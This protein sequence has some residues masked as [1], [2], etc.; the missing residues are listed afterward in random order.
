MDWSVIL[1]GF[2][3]NDMSDRPVLSIPVSRAEKRIYALYWLAVA[4]SLA[5]AVLAMIYLPARPIIHSASGGPDIVRDKYALMAF[6]I[7]ILY[8]ASIAVF[9]PKYPL[10]RSAYFV[11]ITPQNAEVQ[12]TLGR[13]V[14][15][16]FFL[17]ITWLM[18][19]AQA[20]LLAT[21]L[22]GRENPVLLNGV[23]IPLAVLP[24]IVLVCGL[25]I[26]WK[27]R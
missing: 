19:A 18:V 21:W 14:S 9:L 11:K 6:S 3:R 12:Y 20:V 10:H 15:A 27:R 4:V 16:C 23:L 13:Y 24:I 2:F 1:L 5:I 8:C 17:S 25:T 22:Q 26:S 7:F